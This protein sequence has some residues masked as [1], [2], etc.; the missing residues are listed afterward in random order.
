MRL[1]RIKALR[2][3]RGMIPIGA[4]P[5]SPVR[6]LRPE[7]QMPMIAAI[8]S[9]LIGLPQTDEQ[10]SSAALAYGFSLA[11]LARAH[12]TVQTMALDIVVPD[13][14]VDGFTTSLSVEEDWRLARLAEA[15]AERARTDASAVGLSCTAHARHL[16][17][18]ELFASLA[19]QA[20]IN[21]IAIFEAEPRALA[22]GRGLI[23]DLILYGGRPLLVVPAGRQTFAAERIVIAWNGSA[24][25][26][27]AVGDALP[28]LREAR[29]VHVVTV[30]GEKEPAN[31]VPGVELGP[32]LRR[33]GIP[34]TVVDLLMEGGSTAETL[35]RHARQARADMMVVGGFGHTRLREMVLGG[36]TTALLA[37]GPVPLLVSH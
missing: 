23:E 18:N 26:A 34:V 28:F 14:W 36:V 10:G 2:N 6:A 29:D 33:H 20:R 37:D 5:C 31:A 16:T 12:V 3:G 35:R 17:D 7:R 11:Q 4:G 13:V 24:P 32:Y 15:A 30:L 22:F 21:D 9:I 25:A 8:K 1:R 27:R 19:A